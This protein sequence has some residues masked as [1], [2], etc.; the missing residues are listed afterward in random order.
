MQ[1]LPLLGLGGQKAR[2]D[3]AEGKALAHEL[4]PGPA[5]LYLPQ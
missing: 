1:G 3:L 4:L 5:R 2:T